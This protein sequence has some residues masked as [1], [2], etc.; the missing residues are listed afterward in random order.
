MFIEGNFRYYFLPSILRW[1]PLLPAT[2]CTSLA[3]L[4][5]SGGSLVSPSG[6]AGE[7]LRLEML[8]FYV[9][10]GNLNT[11]PHSGVESTLPAEPSPLLYL[12][13]FDR[14]SSNV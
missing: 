7:A 9:G 5:A 12:W 2:A 4:Q 14:I 10:Y 11:A 3:D 6:L 13:V 8:Q 1:Y